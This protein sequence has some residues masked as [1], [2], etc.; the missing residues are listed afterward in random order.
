MLTTMESHPATWENHVKKVVMATNTSAVVDRVHPFLMFG[1]EA[2]LPADLVYGSSPTESSTPAE[3][4]RLLRPSIHS[5]QQAY[6]C[7]KAKRR[8]N[9]G[10]EEVTGQ[11][12]NRGGDH[13]MEMPCNYRLCG[14]KV[15]VK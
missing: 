12:L 14:P 7:A 6:V 3:Y 13:T 9:I 15:Y 4:A 5:L 8:V 1:R 11:Q 2:R 10:S